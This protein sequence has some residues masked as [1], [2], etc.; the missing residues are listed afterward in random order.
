MEPAIGHLK[1]D[2]RMQRCWLQGEIG[3]ALHAL[4]RGLQLA[5]VD[6]GG[7]ASGPQEPFIVLV[8]AGVLGSICQRKADSSRGRRAHR[9][10]RVQDNSSPVRIESSVDEFCRP[11]N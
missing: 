5:L 10:I 2:N 11:L 9:T 6:A 4:C 8:L 3:D 7:G 1:S